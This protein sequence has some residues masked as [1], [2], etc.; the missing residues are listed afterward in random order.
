LS[1]TGGIQLSA[2]STPSILA[3]LADGETPAAAGAAPKNST[4]D[5]KKAKK[6][7]KC[8]DEGGICACEG[9]AF[10]GAELKEELD[11]SKNF[12][13]LKN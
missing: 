12:A 11:T 13:Q 8:A 5:M 7:K 3:S 2:R 1:S 6:S 4:K 10:F 9:I